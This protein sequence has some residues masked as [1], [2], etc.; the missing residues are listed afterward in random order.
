MCLAPACPAVRGVLMASKRGDRATVRPATDLDASAI[1]DVFLTSRQDALPYL[2][3][4]HSDDETRQW[5][6]A[7]VVRRGGVWVAELDGRIAGFLSVVGEE[8]DHLYVR[9]GYYRQ[10]IGDRLLAK[11]KELSP[12]RLRLFTFQRNVRARTFYEARGFRTLDFNDGSR[13]E[14][15]EPDVRYEWVPLP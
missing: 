3:R 15:H 4:V 10:G 1:A 14:E 2:P 7:V 9:P 8:L 5:I 13:N 11:A 6:A 12:G